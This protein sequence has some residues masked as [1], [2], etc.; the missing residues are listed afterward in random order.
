MARAYTTSTASLKIPVNISF[1]CP[2]C[3]QFGSVNKTALL[4]AQATVR[5]YSS[6]AAGQFARQNLA[7]GAESQLKLITESLEKGRL[8]ILLD[9]KG[10]NVN[11]KV[12]CPHCGIRQVVEEDGKRKTLYP[13]AFAVKLIALFFAVAFFPI[14]GMSLSAASHGTTHVYSGAIMVLE[15]VCIAAVIAAILINRNKS[16]KAWTDPVLMEKRYNSVINPN[17]QAVLMLGIGS[18]YNVMVGRRNKISNNMQETR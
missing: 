8:N 15:W 10:R 14:L 11:G 18:T 2:K 7:A 6:S 5:G 1:T 12:I 13:K 17:M 3:R 9:E 4:S 16:K